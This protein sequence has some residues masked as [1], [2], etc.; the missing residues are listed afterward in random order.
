MSDV[1]DIVTLKALWIQDIKNCAL[2]GDVALAFQH[3]AKGKR[4]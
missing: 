2:Q 4:N 1:F 3:P